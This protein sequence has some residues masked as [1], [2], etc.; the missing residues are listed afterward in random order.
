MP[1][2]QRHRLP[3]AAG[4]PET[5]GATGTLGVV[6]PLSG[7]LAEFGEQS[8]MGVLLAARVFEESDTEVRVLVRDSQGRPELAAEAVRDLAADDDVTA[9]VG[10]LAGGECE[11]AAAAAEQAEVPLL[12]LTSRAQIAA[13]RPH[14]LRLR[15]RPDEE[16][17][18]GGVR[19]FGPTNLAAESARGASRMYSRNLLALVRHLNGEEGELKYDL[20]DELVSGA[21]LTHR[22]E[23][24]NPRIRDRAQEAGQ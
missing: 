12:T 22:G 23:V 13:T 2:A 9:I 8:L 4:A 11:A 14:V 16:V 15:T 5:E 1:P 24:M 20:S 10:P 19:I 17:S 18:H 21:L 7:P 6:L 3:P